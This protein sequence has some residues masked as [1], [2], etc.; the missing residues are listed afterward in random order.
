MI[1]TENNA[2]ENNVILIPYLTFPYSL[3]KY[4]S[5]S[6]VHVQLPSNETDL[7]HLISE[8]KE[9]VGLERTSLLTKNEDLV[10]YFNLVTFTRSRSLCHGPMQ[11]L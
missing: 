4:V 10:T 1:D 6:A 3:L 11:S 2:T 9:R 7:T 8:G 5:L